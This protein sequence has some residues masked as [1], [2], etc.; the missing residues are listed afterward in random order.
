MKTYQ[1]FF[2][3]RHLNINNLKHSDN[4]FN[5]G[6]TFTFFDL[7]ISNELNRFLYSFKND[8]V[9]NIQLDNSQVWV[10]ETYPNRALRIGYWSTCYVTHKKMFI[11]CNEVNV[12]HNNDLIHV[13]I[14]TKMDTVKFTLKDGILINIDGF[15]ILNEFKKALIQQE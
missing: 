4:V 11:M 6:N 8:F 3:R 12:E 5:S 14:T 1:S 10:Y 9:L 13:T 7:P 2:K 15:N